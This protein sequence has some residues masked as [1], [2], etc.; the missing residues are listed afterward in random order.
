MFNAKSFFGIFLLI[1]ITGCVDKSRN[2]S[3]S[4]PS[5]DQDN[6][7][8]DRGAL[9]TN[10]ADNIFI[11]NYMSTAEEAVSFASGEGKL[12]DYCDAIDNS[13]ESVGLAEAKLAWQS[14]MDRVQQTEM[15]IVGPAER[16]GSALQSRINSYP[17][18]SLATCALDQ[19]VV[20]SNND[21]NFS[22]SSR[23]LNQ[24]GMGAIE[25]LLFDDDLNH[26]CS[27]QALAADDWS[28]L[29]DSERKTQ[30]CNYAVKL[31]NDVA[32]ASQAIYDRWTL[33]ESPYR[34]EFLSESS[35]GDNFQLV[36]DALFYLETFTKSG[37]LAIPLGINP[38]CS[39]MTC[40]DLVESPFSQ[41]S[42]R[43][44]KTNTQEFLRIFNGGSSVGF[45]DLI[46]NEGYASI[47]NRFKTQSK[48]VIDFIDTINLSL[49]DQIASIQSIDDETTCT[50]SE[51]N[52]DDD[53]A[54]DACSLAGLLKKITDDLKI[55]FVSIVNVPV[56]GRV[57]SDND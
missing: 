15:H 48:D 7:D 55:E 37:K 13:D 21:E 18:G 6:V 39:A 24:R 56:P 9:M 52:P 51:A 49:T 45:D 44:I 54:L 19:A 47:A 27:S 1:A 2:L 29:S 30:R 16:N 31:A 38:K 5:Q 11:P 33:G 20:L 57:Q 10:L 36:T 23:A 53:S 32:D 4:L 42:L 35:L 43:N 25:Y 50:N 26:S 22:V 34:T 12:S 17:L 40:P 3:S 41:S 28:N 46:D 8:F 14:L